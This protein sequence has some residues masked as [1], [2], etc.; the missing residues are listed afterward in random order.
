MTVIRQIY[1]QESQS[2]N[3]VPQTSGHLPG[4][5]AEVC[6]RAPGARGYVDALACVASLCRLLSPAEGRAGQMAPPRG[7]RI[8]TNVAPWAGAPWKVLTSSSN[9]S[10][11]CPFTVVLC[12]RDF[13]SASWRW[14]QSDGDFPS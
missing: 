4:E 10:C 9:N 13:Q 5:V 6:V 8:S 1:G 14:T 12:A 3:R 2:A 11:L 7:L